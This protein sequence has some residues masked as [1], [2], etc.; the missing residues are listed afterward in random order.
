[1]AAVPWRGRVGDELRHLDG[2]SGASTQLASLDA[3][4]NNL[5]NASTPGFKA[6]EAVFSEYL[7]DAERAGAAVQHMR[8]AAVAEMSTNFR[9]GPLVV[10]HRPLDVALRGDGF[11]TI[12]APGGER[13]TR[14]GDLHVNHRRELVTAE[15]HIMLSQARRP[16]HV[17]PGGETVS[18]A[19]D[20]RVL[21]DGNEVG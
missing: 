14:A 21:S 9:T 17:P 20:G 7:I 12:R 16:I 11:F 4:A 10:T 13:Y 18:I 19:P 6:D 3:T 1:M 8:F 15:G 2:A 5:A